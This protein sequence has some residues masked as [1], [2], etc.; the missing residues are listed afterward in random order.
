MTRADH[1]RIQTDSGVH[2]NEL[3]DAGADDSWSRR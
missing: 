2:V 1:R 3:L